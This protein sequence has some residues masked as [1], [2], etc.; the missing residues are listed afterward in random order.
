M[1]KKVLIIAYQ[2]PPMGGSGVQRTSKFVKNLHH[3]GYEP[4]VLTRDTKDVSLLDESLLKDIPKETKIYR[5]NAYDKS[6]STKKSAIPSKIIGRKVLIPD[7]AR[8]W[9]LSLHKKALKIIED[10][11]IDLIYTTSY[12]Y[13]DHLLGLFIKKTLKGKVKWVCDFRDEWSNNP[14]TKDNPYSKSRMDKE[15]KM[16]SEVIKYA[17]KLITNTP[18]MRQN[19]IDIHS[20]DE[21]RQEDF[22][23]I[24]NGYDK[25]DFSGLE[26]IKPKNDKFTI[27]Y[28][29]A[30]YG[31]R[32]PDYFFEAVQRLVESNEINIDRLSINFIGNYKR[33]ALL[34]NI[35]KFGIDKC[36]IVHDY[37]PH[38]EALKKLVSSDALLLLEGGG[39]GSDAF[40]TG[41][42]FEYMNTY[43]PVIAVLPY[44]CAFDIVN[45]TNIGETAYFENIDEIK[46]V[47]LKFYEMWDRG[48]EYNEQNFELIQ[49][50]ER[51]E[52]TKKLAEVFDSL[53]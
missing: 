16:E 2:F 48:E 8:L 15:L 24:P 30:M 39:V 32:K 14:Y 1:S 5:T 9:E 11:K 36:V 26:N 47:I 51:Y 31:R 20:L 50:F 41:K 22:F 4:I 23:T 35:K 18:V 27:T 25:D 7:Q 53:V 46:K 28:T 12:P 19:F 43:R 34:D 29:G 3:F 52:L 49:S 37:M 45:E 42:V 33:D 44:G 40:Y 21:K 6:D 13:S 17:D 38:K 10:E